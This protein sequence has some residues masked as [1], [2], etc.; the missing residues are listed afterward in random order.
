MNKALVIAALLGAVSASNNQGWFY[1]NSDNTYDYLIKS[2]Y[3]GLGY[4]LQADAGYSTF[5]YSRILPTDQQKEAY[6]LQLYSF[7][8]LNIKV[9]LAGVYHDRMI[10]SF[11]PFSI[12]PYVQGIKWD[13]LEAGN[14]LHFYAK[15]EKYVDLGLF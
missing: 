1:P 5:Y 9:E 11:I 15:G 6:G 4:Y 10:F 8:D 12:V 13:R 2:D 7:V 3:F 14:G